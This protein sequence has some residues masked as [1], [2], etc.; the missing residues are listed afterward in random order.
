M[1]SDRQLLLAAL[2]AGVLAACGEASSKPARDGSPGASQTIT[3][4]VQPSI[5][6]VNPGE[7]VTFTATLWG[8]ANTSVTWEVRE[9]DGG[10]IDAAGT[11]TAPTSP[12]TFHV[13]PR[14]VSA[15]S[16][17]PSIT[18]SQALTAVAGARPAT[19]MATVYVS[20]FGA[21]F[22]V[23]P[24]GRDSDPGTEDQPFATL[25]RAQ[26]TVR[27]LKS[28]SGLPADGVAVTI[29][30]GIYERSATLTLTSQ[31][32]GEPGK[33]IVYRA[34]S[35][36]Q[37]RLV[38]G[39]VLDPAWFAEVTSASTVW[40]RVDA[41]ARGK[42]VQVDLGAH[43][44]TDYGALSGRGFYRLHPAGLELF[45]NGMPMTL[46][47]WPDPGETDSA[48]DIQDGLAR[49]ASAI[50]G[51]Q[52]TYSG[53]RPERWAAASDVWMHGYWG[54]S[55]ADFHVPVAAMDTSTRT[56]T[57]GQATQYGISAD[58]AYCAENLLEE[59]T[60]PGEWWLD[61][62]TGILYFWPPSPL[63][64]GEFV[65]STLATPIVSIQGAS[66]VT[67]RGLVFEVGRADLVE[68]AS[69][70]HD[71]LQS[72]TLRNAG[73]R[74]AVVGGTDNGLDHCVVHH[75]GDEAVVL[76]G[77]VRAS[78]TPGA[79]HVTNSELHHYGRW[80]FTYTPGVRLSGVGHLVAHNLIHDAPFGAVLFSG[81]NHVIEMNDIHHVCQLGSD[82]GAVYS[83]R[84]WGYR[85]NE[86]RY[87]FI[88]DVSASP[89]WS[90]FAQ[91]R[92]LG[93]HGIYLDD[94]VSGIH[95]HGNVL[96]RITGG[97]AVVLGG[98][99]DNIVEDNVIARCWRALQADSRGIGAINTT[100][101]DSWNLLQRLSGDGVR[102]QQE[103]W[104]SAYPDLAVI[105]NDP[106][107]LGS[108]GDVT[109]SW[110]HPEGSVF[111][112]NLGFANAQW[113]KEGTYHS[114][115]ATTLD[116]FAVDPRTPAANNLVAQTQPF[117]D[118]ADGDLTLAPGVLSAI[119]GFQPIPLGQI[120][121]QP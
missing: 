93:T 99:R 64:S 29:R 76:G 115:G 78:L 102:Y 120:G 14:V 11:Y 40:P 9:A 55:W 75:T 23:A 26:A 70:S 106:A 48:A 100:P 62:A 17:A 3:I 68:I 35:G 39:R 53:T 5:A 46:G 88:H 15:D 51:T 118:E 31:D 47:R 112:R 119:P 77:G 95:V 107:A 113:L 60:T 110:R 81:N 59:I 86:I 84:D 36:E 82:M 73:N 91:A 38:G 33:P 4:E 32:S 108:P 43:G 10:M 30:G 12:G 56:V 92:G 6:E 80:T 13:L 90:A 49:V 63:T 24:G 45:F 98:G 96:Y 34:S 18:S 72:C 83:G 27:E 66:H 28:S 121:I 22:F 1:T 19:A 20:T 71:S 74:G 37:V 104:A 89:R 109:N 21:E 114:A 61:R 42:L 97:N 41:A 50:S 52:F 8:M 105:P 87:N 16:V 65:V 111:S 58:A 7:R 67:F 103:P 94:C 79:N 101:D 57:L 69:G 116:E 25:E 44:I 85:G 117:V 2:S 54:N